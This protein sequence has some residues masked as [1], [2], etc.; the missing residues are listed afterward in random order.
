M[1]SALVSIIFLCASDTGYAGGGFNQ[2]QA[3]AGPPESVYTSSCRESCDRGAP[4]YMVKAMLV[5]PVLRRR[6][7]ET[8]NIYR[9]DPPL[10]IACHCRSAPIQDRNDEDRRRTA[11]LVQRCI[12]QCQ[13]GEYSYRALL[14]ERDGR[15]HQERVS[16][17]DFARAI[18]CL[19]TGI[20]QQDPPLKNRRRPDD[21]L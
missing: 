15:E 1:R 2:V 6:S 17:L 16:I 19:C 20:R 13:S 21:I 5:D 9:A 11:S 4:G 18:V 7:M 10:P 8:V 14:V 3:D 12:S